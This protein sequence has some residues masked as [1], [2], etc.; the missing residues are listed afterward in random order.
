MWSPPPLV[1]ATLALPANTPIPCLVCQADPVT[2]QTFSGTLQNAQIGRLLV[3]NGKSHQTMQFVVPPTFRGVASS[4]GV[5]KAA[6]V[7]SAKPGLLARVTYR[8]GAG[9]ANQ[10]TEVL[11][12]TLEQCRALQAAERIGHTPIDCP[13]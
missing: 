8:T 7:A 5:I 10:V 6:T 11:L 3:F 9:G 13:D 1:D 2:A 12:L 4:D